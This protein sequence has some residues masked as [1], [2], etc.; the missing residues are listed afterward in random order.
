MKI[1]FM[2]ATFCAVNRDTVTHAINS[3]TFIIL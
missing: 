3:I 2:F 1:A